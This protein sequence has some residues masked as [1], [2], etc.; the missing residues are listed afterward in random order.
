MGIGCPEYVLLFRKL[1][2][3]TSRAYADL[4]V[5][6]DKK[7]YSLAR[8]QIDAHASWKSSG[9]SL[10]SYEDMKGAGIDKIRHL[11]GNCNL[12]YRYVEKTFTLQDMINLMPKHIGEYALNWY[13]SD[14]TF[15]Y[16]RIDCWDRFDVLEDLSF[17][18]NDN[19]TI[20]DVAY[21]MLC[22]LADGGYLNK[23]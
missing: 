3:D 15:R 8:W 1:P 7:E 17:T 19:V 11:Y 22:K 9:N 12:T 18:F 21:G 14:M 16:D 10:L 23:K 13:I 5:T 6:K 2:S 20:L 4:P